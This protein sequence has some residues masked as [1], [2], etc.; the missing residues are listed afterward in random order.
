MQAYEKS[1]EKAQSWLQS[2]NIDQNFK[3]QIKTLIESKSKSSLTDC[4]ASDLNFGTGGIRALTGVGSCRLNIYTIR[5]INTTLVEHLKKSFSQKISVAISYDTRVH[6]LEFAQASAQVLA[7][8]GIKVYITKTAAPTPFLSFIVR[9][10]KCQAGICI[11]ASHNPPAYNGFKLYNS[12]GRQITPPEDKDF[13]ETY[14]NIELL[15]LKAPESYASLL[16]KECIYEISEDVKE[17]FLERLS[18]LFVDNREDN[19]KIVYTAL[20]GTGA[21]L[22]VRLLKKL[23]FNEVWSVKEQD[24]ADGNFS[25][26]DSPNPEDTSCFAAAKKLGEIKKADILL[27]TDPDADRY[28]V[29]I[30]E[31]NS[32][33]SLSGNETSCLIVDHLLSNLKSKKSLSSKNFIIK[34]MVT[35]DLIADIA[36][37][38][39]LSCFNTPI[40]FKWITELA[41]KLGASDFIC[42]C[43]ESLGFLTGDVVA[44]K[45]GLLG[46]TIFCE[47]LSK[48]KAKNK[49]VFER[50]DELYMQHG[51]YYNELLSINLYNKTPELISSFIEKIRN[52][53]FVEIAGIKVQKSLDY[54]NTQ[55]SFNSEIANFFPKTDILVFFLANGTKL[56]IRP[57]GTEPKI[58]IYAQSKKSFLQKTP[59]ALNAVKISVKKETKTIL[60]EIKK[61]FYF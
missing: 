39:N 54:L 36:N 47:L 8:K 35:S 48:L 57:S 59:T 14:N 21:D 17:L 25:S 26:V 18:K 6:S 23:S 20:H 51:Y 3:K 13:I 49:T 45:D 1:L 10:Y 15:T 30:R 37:T 31:N 4:F 16:K 11:T 24:R 19:L 42:G 50:L 60:T 44:D 38:Y 33:Q 5:K 56:S 27:A 53:Q 61:L 52:E 43:E 46:C 9:E 40:G 12:E 7:D 29:C 2:D 22:V 32:W 28:G 58:K 34:T 41:S 55:S